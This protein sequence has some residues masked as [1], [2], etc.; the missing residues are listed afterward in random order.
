M[1]KLIPAIAV[2]L[3][4]CG[5]A[6]APVDSSVLVA[7]IRGGTPHVCSKT[8]WVTIPSPPGFGRTTYPMT[9]HY[10]CYSGG[11]GGHWRPAKMPK[12]GVDTVV[13]NSPWTVTV[14]DY[15]PHRRNAQGEWVVDTGP[16]PVSAMTADI[17]PDTTKGPVCGNMH[18]DTATVLEFEPPDSV[19][20]PL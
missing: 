16:F 9:V 13:T 10:V 15:A 11:S 1:K 18:Y 4:S 8:V 20:G 7:D 19:T 14:W 3:L 2:L 17:P 12:V 5:E 6:T